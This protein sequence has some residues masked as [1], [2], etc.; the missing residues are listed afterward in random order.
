MLLREVRGQS[1]QCFRGATVGSR[2]DVRSTP[3]SSS[4]RRSNEFM[5][6]DHIRAALLLT[7]CSPRPM[8]ALVRA[9]SSKIFD[10]RR[11]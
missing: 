3:Q 7:C 2:A 5:L 8:L 4:L 10:G 1:S 6:V 9:T 11:L